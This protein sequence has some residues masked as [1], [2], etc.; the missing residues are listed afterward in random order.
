MVPTGLMRIDGAEIDP[1]RAVENWHNTGPTAIAVAGQAVT[2]LKTRDVPL[3]Q[4]VWMP[5]TMRKWPK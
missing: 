1:L 3:M 4:W 2:G 5:S